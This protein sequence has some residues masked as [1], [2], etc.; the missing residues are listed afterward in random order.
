MLVYIQ[1]KW[2]I[3]KAA[4]EKEKKI[5]SQKERN[6]KKKKTFKGKKQKKQ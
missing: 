5:E 6:A 1:K 2:Q 4:N 3:C